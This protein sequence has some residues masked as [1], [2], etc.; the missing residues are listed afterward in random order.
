VTANL[1]AAGVACQ[2]LQLT[3]DTRGFAPSGVVS[4]EVSCTA[5]LSDLFLLAVP[6]SR[7]LNATSREVIDT[8]RGAGS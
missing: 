8:Y 1:T 5:D 2:D 3:T 6:A 4:V 7:V